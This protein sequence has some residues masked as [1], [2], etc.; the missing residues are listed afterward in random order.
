MWDYSYLATATTPGTFVALSPR[1]E[2]RYAPKT[3]GHGAQERVVIES[4]M[5]TG[6]LLQRPLSARSLSDLRARVGK[7]EVKS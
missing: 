6:A 1:A 7:K 3:F 2:E 4:G 5:E